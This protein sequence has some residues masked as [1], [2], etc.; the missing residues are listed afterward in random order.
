MKNFLIYSL[1]IMMGSGLFAQVN[2]PITNGD[3]E[4]QTALFKSKKFWKK[5]AV[6]GMFFNENAEPSKFDVSNSGL[7]P[8]EGIDN[9]QAL[10]SKVNDAEGKT[11]DVTLA[12]GDT[13]ISNYG[14]GTYKFTF[15]VKTADAFSA[16]P[17]WIVCSAIDEKKNDV[18]KQTLTHVDNGGTVAW[19]DLNNGYQEQ[20]ITIKLTKNPEGK[21]AQF[22]RL[23]IQH[24]RFDNTYFFDD[25]SLTK[26]D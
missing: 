13:D 18:S 9:S 17:F 20:S 4:D 26:L 23:Q 6:E 12:V 2:I 5:W 8:G 21:D 11:A 19:K 10:K 7:A 16:R 24:G 14:P 3:L 25:F 15:Y 22:L 1:T